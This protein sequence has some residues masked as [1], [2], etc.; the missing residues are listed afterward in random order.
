MP[1]SAQTLDF[2]FMN[3]LH[4]SRDWFN[5]RR[6]EYD[7]DVMEPMRKLVS[8]LAPVM[9][10]IDP[11]LICEPKVNKS[12][13]RIFRDT[14]F[15]KDKSIF[16]DTFWCTFMRDKKL[17]HGMPGFFFELSPRGFRYGC[18]YYQARPEAVDTVRKMILE[19]SPDFKKA[20]RCIAE[21]N[22]FKMMGERY[23]K[24]KFPDASEEMRNW[25][26]L[27]NHGV[28]YSSTDFE[29]LFSENLVFQ[30][31]EDFRALKPYYNFL[32]K[33]ELATA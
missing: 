14:R 26:D 17:Y 16:R 29:L 7:R 33:A 6:E 3:K 12:I 23:K 2:L 27:K 25:L 15:S 11:L 24:T 22:K 31:A 8:D 18:G 9:M 30:L 4:D 20:E 10:E 19:G 1:F 13:S 21:N 5:E 28:I 32:L